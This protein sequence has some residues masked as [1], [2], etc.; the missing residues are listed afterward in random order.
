MKQAFSTWDFIWLSVA[1][2]VAYELG[3]G[4]GTIVVP[5]LAEAPPAPAASA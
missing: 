4:S 3:R 5:P 2:L 1:A